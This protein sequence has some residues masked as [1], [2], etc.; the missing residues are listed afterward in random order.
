MV[1]GL[2]LAT[3]APASAHDELIA[4]TPSAGE[5]LT[6]APSDVSLSF[7]ADVLTIGAAIIVVDESGHDWAAAE[8]TVS[9]GTVT[10]PL[11]AGMAEAGYEIRWRVVS[12]DGHPISGLIPFTVGD[13][14]PL[15][16]A[17][18]GSGSSTQ[19]G[20]DPRDDDTDQ[21]ADDS[22]ASENA[23]VLRVAAFGAGGAALAA[24]V[25]IIFSL[26]R[27]RRTDSGDDG[28]SERPLP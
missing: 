25:F 16:R 8:P 6:V 7:S 15:V 9:E 22:A 24:G 21:S 23:G 20:T 26:L 10:V 13:A 11:E 12:S 14:D 19:T 1:A 27:R 18:S 2:V 4:S 28:T 17:A 3:P 5:R